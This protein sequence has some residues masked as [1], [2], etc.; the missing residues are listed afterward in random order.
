M[1]GPNIQQ[2]VFDAL[3]P[4]PEAASIFDL[5]RALPALLKE[6]VQEALKRLRERKHVE[7]VPGRRWV[8]RRAKGVDRP[9]DGR[10]G[11]ANWRH[12]LKGVAF[13]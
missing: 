5:Y 2:R 11:N 6:S 10:L 1:K 8:Y 13:L 12:R 4:H 9:A 7:P 3:P